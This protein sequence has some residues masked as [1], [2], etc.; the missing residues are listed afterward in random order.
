MKH[1][2]GH[3][4]PTARRQRIDSALRLRLAGT[5]DHVGTLLQV[6]MGMRLGAMRLDDRADQYLERRRADGFGADDAHVG[7]AGV[8]RRGVG[9][10][11]RRA[12]HGGFHVLH[13][14]WI[15]AAV[16]AA[17]P[18]L[19]SAFTNARSSSGVD[20]RLRPPVLAIS[21]RTAGSASAARNSSLSFAT[22]SLGVFT[23]T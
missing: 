7:S 17:D 9:G 5:F 13:S 8:V 19:I 15:P 1:A 20:P 18:L 10:Q 2:G 6:G 4:A 14:G 21:W 11:L 16:T 23:G 22:V 12:D 3:I